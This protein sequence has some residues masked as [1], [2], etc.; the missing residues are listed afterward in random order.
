MFNVNDVDWT[1]NN[2]SFRDKSINEALEDHFERTI[3]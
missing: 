1:E 2:R 3:S